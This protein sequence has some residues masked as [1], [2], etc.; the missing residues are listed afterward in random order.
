MLEPA[1]ARSQIHGPGTPLA[2]ISVLDALA[3]RTV[4]NKFL[5]SAQSMTSL[6]SLS[7]SLVCVVYMC[8]WHVRVRDCVCCRCVNGTCVWV[9]MC[10]AYMWM[11]GECEWLCMV[12]MCEWHVRV[13]D[14]ASSRQRTLSI[15]LCCS[16]P[17][18]LREG[19]SLKP[20]S[21][22]VGCAF[23]CHPILPQHAC[24]C[25]HRLQT[26]IHAHFFMWVLRI[27]Q[28]TL[29]HLCSPSV[30]IFF[31]VPTLRQGTQADPH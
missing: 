8:E 25:T 28:H 13:S 5:F 2:S 12:H 9:I 24:A 26:Y 22:F 10:G 31:L 15:F 14:Y 4:K 20:A 16:L 1:S 30:W 21:K 6:P 11:A 19:C 18:P 29:S 17:V 7:S 3:F 27:A 23:L